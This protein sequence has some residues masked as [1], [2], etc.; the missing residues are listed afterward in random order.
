MDLVIRN[1]TLPDGRSG[2]DIA[3]EDGRIA[4]LRPRLDVVGRQELDAGGRLV[5]PPFVDAHFHLDTALSLGFPRLNRTGTLIEGIALWREIEPH[6]THEWLVE[7]G[8][9]Y[10]DWAI[11][12]GIQ[13]IRSHVDTT[14]AALTG[15]T[16]MLE[17]KRAVKD[18]LDL[19]LVAFP[20]QGIYR[21]PG[22]LANL[23]RAL[24]L[25]VEV[26]GGIPHFERT[27]ADGTRSVVTLCEIAA[28]RGLL[29]DLHCDE[30]DDPASRHIETL[31]AE[32]IRLGLKGRTAGS[33]L[34]SMHSMDN[35][36]ASKL[37]PLMAEAEI[38]AIANPLANVTLQGRH[39][40]YPKRRGMMRVPELLQAGVNVAFGHDSVMD[41]FYSLGT[42]DM[43][44][45]AGMGAHLGHM[46]GI[47][48]NECLLRR[49]HR[50][51]GARDA[52]SRLRAGA[53]QER[54][55]R[56]ARRARSDRCHPPFGGPALC[57]SARQD[58][59]PLGAEDRQTRHS[60]PAFRRRLRPDGQAADPAS[61][62]R[63]ISSG[64]S[65]SS[66][67]RSTRPESTK[68][69]LAMALSEGSA[70]PTI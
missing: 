56:R 65:S 37:I 28:K 46:T 43:L 33:H 21:A 29:L 70:E 62:G 38:Q 10:C 42:G 44:A 14:H 9:Q 2:I 50:E 64:M 5:S 57:R 26:V 30:T 35:Y 48:Q 60:R 63:R 7:R 51:R 22:G 17:V 34:T 67:P 31:A 54:R 6:L 53:G 61:C 8:L 23:E 58:R 45:V 55:S 11:A 1:A 69:M 36:Y 16:A 24:D 49:G 20:Q 52:S 68:M 59:R 3:I 47:D 39:D 32:T 15:V 41:P 12:Q 4:A 40:T 66:T 18:Y 19:Q 25:G 13:A 27:A